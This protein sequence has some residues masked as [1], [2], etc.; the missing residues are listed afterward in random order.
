MLTEKLNTAFDIY[1]CKNPLMYWHF[2][3]K[4]LLKK[5]KHLVFQDT[6]VKS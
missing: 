5:K 6:D 2:L 4:E 3:I 1:K